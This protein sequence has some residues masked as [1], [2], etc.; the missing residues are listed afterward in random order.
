MVETVSALDSNRARSLLT[1]LGIVIGISAVIAMTAIIGGVKNALVSE[2]GLSQARLVSI[3]CYYGRSMTSADVRDMDGEL[4]S[5]F[6]YVTAVNSGSASVTAQ[7]KTS[8]AQVRG[9]YPEYASVTG[10]KMKQGRFI[11]GG[12]ADGGAFSVVLDEAGV[13]TLFGSADAQAVGQTLRLDGAEYRIVGVAEASGGY[14]ASDSVSLYMPFSTC[15]QRVIGSDEVSEAYGMARE[16]VDAE[17]AADAAKEWLIRRFRIPSEEQENSLYVITMKSIMEQLDVMMAS[18]QALMTVV[19]SI[20]LLVGGIGIMNM[21]LTNV[22]ERIREIGLRKALGARRRD[23]TRQFLMESVCLTL[24]GG[25]FGILFGYAFA[26][27]LA[28][29]AG[30]ALSLGEGVTLT[31]SISPASVATVAGICVLIGVV[32]GYYPA[33]R[34]ARL[35]PVEALRYQ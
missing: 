13:K 9:V 6:E 28:G 35:N 10:V 12:E 22:T 19:A 7:K 24:V 20:S 33:R 17:R 16:D 2:M 14:V 27:G 21:M 23:I 31:P 3:M 18:F 8:A 15:A 30:A 32:F 34:A 25:V 5:Y 4:G 1:V 29:L 11:T 26:F